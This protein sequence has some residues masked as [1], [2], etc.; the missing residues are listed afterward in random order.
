M[1]SVLEGVLVDIRMNPT[2]DDS[3][4]WIRPSNTSTWFITYD[5]VVE[6]IMSKG[7]QVQLGSL[8][9]TPSFIQQHT[10]LHEEWCIEE[11]VKP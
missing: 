7:D 2:I 4:I 8:F 5:H 9:G 3:E 1:I 10:N 11:T 6:V